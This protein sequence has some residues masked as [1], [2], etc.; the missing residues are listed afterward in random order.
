M[1]QFDLDTVESACR[2]SMFGLGSSGFCLSCGEEREG[3]EPDAEHY[4]CYAC[5][6]FEVMGAEMLYVMIA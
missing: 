3:C 5:G 2:E 1:F 6:E 4:E